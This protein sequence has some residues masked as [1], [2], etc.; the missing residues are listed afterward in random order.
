MR[1]E[2]KLTDGVTS[3]MNLTAQ[4]QLHTAI[5]DNYIPTS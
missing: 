3:Q 1:F 4:R 2:I 5:N